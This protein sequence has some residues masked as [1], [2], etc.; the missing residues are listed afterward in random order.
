MTLELDVACSLVLGRM[1]LV[2]QKRLICWDFPTQTALGFTEDG[3]TNRKYPVNRLEHHITALKWPPHSQDLNPTA[4]LRIGV[5]REIRI[6]NMQLT[7]LQQ[8]HNSILSIWA[9]CLHTLLNLCHKDS[10]ECK[11]GTNPSTSKVCRTYWYTGY[12]KNII[13]FS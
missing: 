6:V 5:E 4:P 10:H 12:N 2:L 11:K 7:N 8:L 3:L 1:L 9:K 13:K